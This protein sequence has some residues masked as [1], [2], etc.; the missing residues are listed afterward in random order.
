M[1]TFKQFV[2]EEFSQ[3][4]KDWMKNN[5]TTRK[6]QAKEPAE[7]S[8][9]G[10]SDPD[11]AKKMHDKFDAAV[12]QKRAENGPK[13]IFAGSRHSDGNTVK[14]IDDR[15]IK[16]TS[17]KPLVGKD[18]AVKKALAAKGYDE[19][20]KRVTAVPKDTGVARADT[21]VGSIQKTK[22]PSVPIPKAKPADLKPKQTFAQAF[23]S[24]K[25]G[26]KFTWNGKTYTRR[27]K[28]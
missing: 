22:T 25:E 8:K 5:D 12:A 20:G 24:A 1:K 6:M 15:K 18:P 2:S 21:P 11:W 16:V 17:D 23:S 3:G 13:D 9:F 4:M 14:V 7:P 28:K 10:P 19:T 27:T 26:S